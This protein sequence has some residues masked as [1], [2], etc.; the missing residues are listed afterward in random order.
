MKKKILIIILL[1]LLVCTLIVLQLYNSAN[2]KYF[3]LRAQVC[4]EKAYL[5]SEPISTAKRIIT[6]RQNEI[7]FYSDSLNY[8]EYTGGQYFHKVRYKNKIGWIQDEALELPEDQYIDS[9][10]MYREKG[11]LY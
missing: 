3:T 10:K 1:L 11:P 2:Y 7:V 5:Q 4:I 9:L 6:L 8:K